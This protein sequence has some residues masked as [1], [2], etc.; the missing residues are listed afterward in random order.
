MPLT[1]EP[2]LNPMLMNNFNYK[3]ATENDIDVLVSSR[4]VF[5]EELNPKPNAEEWSNL[6]IELYAYF[7]EALKKQ[8]YV[9]VIAYLGEQWI[10]SGGMMVFTR[11]GNFKNPT[12][13]GAYIMTMY[14]HPDYRK[15]GLGSNI[16]H[17]LLEKG[18]ELDLAFFELHATEMGAHVYEQAGFKVH[19]QPTYRLLTQ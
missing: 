9:G 1:N 10:A 14:T 11:P 4:I 7:T 12:G 2:K 8:E 15:K 3:Y 6:K 17:L 19:H 5:L 16:I 18:K 13:K